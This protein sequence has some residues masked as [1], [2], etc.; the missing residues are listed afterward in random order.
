MK[1][2]SE[3]MP[4]AVVVTLKGNFMGPPETDDLRAVIQKHLDTGNVKFVIDLKG[5]K[6]INSLGL[7]ALIG[8]YSAAQSKGG[9]IVVIHASEKV[10]NLFMITQLINIF[11]HFDNLNDALEALK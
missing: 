6:W 2:Q 10:K 11:R 5:L 8:S 3:V 1:I 7:G 4:Q 9:G